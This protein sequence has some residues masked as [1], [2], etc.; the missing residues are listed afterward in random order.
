MASK[1]MSYDHAAYTVP[2]V[3]GYET[4]AGASGVVGKFV[5]FTSML[6]KSAT[7]TPTTTGTLTAAGNN[8]LTF[9]VI[10][11]NG[12]TTTSVGFVDLA[13]LGTAQVNQT[14]T[15]FVLGGG[16]TLLTVGQM[17]VAKRGTDATQKEAITYEFLLQPGAN[18]TV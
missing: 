10:S 2:H 1:S 5:A 9:S 12:T 3:V 7:V 15:N 11:N 6:I 4:V 13:S 17:L 14:G 18:V 8:S 16:T